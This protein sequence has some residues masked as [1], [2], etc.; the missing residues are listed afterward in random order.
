MEITILISASLCHTS[1]HM[2]AGN[3]CGLAY[4][5]ADPGHDVTI[6]ASTAR[7]LRKQMV[8]ET[9]QGKHLDLDAELVRGSITDTDMLNEHFRAPNS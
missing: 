6:V 5:L 7:A 1:R 4:S 3:E 2:Y 8:T 9:A